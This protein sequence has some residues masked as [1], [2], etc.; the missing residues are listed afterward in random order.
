MSLRPRPPSPPPSRPPHSHLL[1]GEGCD[2]SQAAPLLQ[3]LPLCLPVEVLVPLAAA[4]KQ[5]VSWGRTGAS[6]RDLG[7]RGS[8]RPPPFPDSM[9]TNLT[10]G[11]ALLDGCSEGGHARAGPHQ[12]HGRV[13]CLWE[14]QAPGTH[15]Q[16]HLDRSWC[17]RG[18]HEE[19]QDWLWCKVT[20]PR[21]RTNQ[22]YLARGPETPARRSRGPGGAP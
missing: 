18:W 14:L 15:P 8:A 2:E 4:E 11:H 9:L 12:D 17:R 7:P 16:G 13:S 10:P 21:S 19:A 3:L 5:D 22:G 1:P 20:P 6:S